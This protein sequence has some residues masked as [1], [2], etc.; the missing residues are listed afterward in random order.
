MRKPALLKQA[1]TIDYTGFKLK[2]I[3]EPRFRHLLWLLFWPIYWLR[4]PLVEL[5]NPAEEYNIIYC[6]LDGLIPFNE[7]FIIPYMFWT[8]G[9][10]AMCAYALKYDVELFENYSKFLSIAISIS[11][12]CF[13]I[14]PSCQN[15]RPSVFRRDNILTDCVKL[16]YA[17]DTNTNVFPSEHAIGAIAV[18]LASLN[19]SGL[20]TPGGQL[21]T[22]LFA[23]LTCM[24]TVFL[25][26][27]SVLDILF[28]LP[29]CAVAYY[30]SFYRHKKLMKKRCEQF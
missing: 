9:M 25:K 28:A 12:L 13:L 14:Y 6:S 5:F 8:L 7:L 23:V 11:T 1:K 24:S 19:T 29:V 4:Y 3:S 2:K 30:F 16:I 10:L 18:W 26:Q 22:G 15:L 20:R 21:L 17:V 27:H